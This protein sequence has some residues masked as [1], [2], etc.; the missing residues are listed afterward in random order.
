[1]KKLRLEH[2]DVVVFGGAARMNFHGVATVKAGAAAERW[3]LTFR[4]AG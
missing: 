3:N 1:M 4:R 2:G